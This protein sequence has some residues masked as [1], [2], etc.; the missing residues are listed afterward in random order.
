MD[1]N[2]PPTIQMLIGPDKEK[3]GVEKNPEKEELKLLESS[4]PEE[5]ESKKEVLEEDAPKI[6][7]KRFRRMV[8]NE[9]R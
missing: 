5:T 9:N 1:M 8:P 7:P 2:G 4:K 3:K 6:F